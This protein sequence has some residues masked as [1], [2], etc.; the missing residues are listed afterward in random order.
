MDLLDLLQTRVV[1]GDGPMGTLLIEQGVPLERCF[2]ELCVSHP[3]RIRRIHEQYID[4]GARVIKTNTFGANAVRLERCSFDGRVAEI[5]YAAAA[6]ARQAAKGKDVTV[7]GS[8]GPLGI[9]ADEALARGIDRAQCFRQQIE[10][11]LDG[12]VDLIFFETFMD[13][14]EL[15]IALQAKDEGGDALAI[16]SFACTAEGRLA[17]GMPL[18][19]AREKLR[20]A[21]AKIVGV[22]CMDGPHS[23]ARLLESA[24]ARYLL[25]AYPNAGYPKYHEGRFIYPATPENFAQ[26]AREMAAHGARL[27]GGCCGTTPFHI[28]AM[29]EAIT[30]LERVKAQAVRR[31]N[32]ADAVTGLT[33]FLECQTTAE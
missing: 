16:C 32:R 26:S 9:S 5:N 2:E 22:N 20:E 21:G 15:A 24:S 12:G 11:R 27:V 28:Q 17:S 10:A 25:T 1:C 18:T 3:E 23:V 13:F 31:T 30:N 8:V 19:D 6:L 33:S 29:A 4:A 14:E 7:A